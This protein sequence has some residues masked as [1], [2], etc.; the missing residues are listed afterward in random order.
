MAGVCGNLDFY[1]LVGHISCGANTIHLRQL[2]WS[3]LA[4]RSD[5]NAHYYRTLMWLCPI[6]FG[7]TGLVFVAPRLHNWIIITLIMTT[8]L[9]CMVAGVFLPRGGLEEIL[10]NI[11]A[12]TMGVAM[13]G[14]AL[15]SALVLPKYTIVAGI[16]ATVMA[17]IAIVGPRHRRHYIF[18]ELA[19]IFL[20]HGSMILIALSIR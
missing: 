18:F 3:K 5:A 2:N 1:I 19:F 16:I 6:L 10:H 13:L 11:F 20:S 17:A 7:L 15:V 12:Y 9:C 4:L 14:L 8:V